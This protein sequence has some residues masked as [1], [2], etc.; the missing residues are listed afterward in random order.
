MKIFIFVAAIFFFAWPIIS[1]DTFSIVAVDSTSREVGSAGGSCLDLFSV[2]IS[3]PGFLADLLPDTGAINTQSFYVAGNQT[4][5]RKRM[6]MGDTPQEIID[7]LAKQDVQGNS[8]QR[9]YGI[10]GFTGMHAD[11][12]GFTG[13]NCIDYKNH[14]TGSVQGIHYAIQGNILLGQVVL[15]S[16]ESRFRRA[17]GDLACRLMA[18]LQGA[19]LPGADTRCADNN[20]STLFAFLKVAQPGDT[21]GNPSFSIGVRTHEGDGVE[22]VDTL[23]LIFDAMH[24]CTTSGSQDVT[25]DITW[26]IFPNPT[27]SQI[28][29]IASE[30]ISGRKYALCDTS[31]HWIYYGTLTPDD[32]TIR[33]DALPSGQYLL[34]IERAGVK[35]FVVTK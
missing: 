32:Y 20:T 35:V 23:Q 18:A 5:A 13:V 19:K 14:I 25:D 21:Y 30:S 24:N 4:N 28:H 26:T 22:P 8:T 16:M 3:D 1:Q 7:W 9:Q 12:A 27:N 17:T 29:I 10:A 15:D 33:T 34:Y 11:A 6:R 31:G 2:G